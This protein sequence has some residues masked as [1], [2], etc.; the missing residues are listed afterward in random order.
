MPGDL[1]MADGSTEARKELTRRL[2]RMRSEMTAT[3]WDLSAGLLRMWAVHGGGRIQFR[4]EAEDRRVF[5]PAVQAAVLEAWELARPVVKE[6]GG[7]AELLLLLDQV[8]GE[9]E[10]DAAA[11][12]GIAQVSG[13]DGDA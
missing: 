8:A 13:M 12:E 7:V 3:E 9:A 5:T 10:R 11:L 2:D 1:V 4:L 6:S